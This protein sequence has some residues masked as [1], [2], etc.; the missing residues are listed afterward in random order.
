MSVRWPDWLSVSA[1]AGALAGAL[2][3]VLGMAADLATHDRA[4]RELLDQLPPPSAR[5]VAEHQAREAAN[6]WHRTVA[7]GEMF[8][9]FGLAVL[10]LAERARRLRAERPIDT[11]PMATASA[12]EF[13][14]ARS[15]T[16]L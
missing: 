8:L 9:I 2:L 5:I 16:T 10:Y 13:R 4:H 7:A 1:I 6:P 12:R 14:P 15:G 11:R 3:L